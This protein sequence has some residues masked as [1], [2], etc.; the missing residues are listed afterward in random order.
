MIDGRQ[1]ERGADFRGGYPGEVNEELAWFAGRYL[2]RFLA[3]EK[4]LAPPVRILV[5]RDG[6]LS[7]APLYDALIRGLADAGATPIPVELT[8]TDALVWGIGTGVATATAGCMVTASHNPP[9]DNGIKMLLRGKAAVETISPKSLC[10]YF[11][12]DP[13][14]GEGLAADVEARP[15][16]APSPCLQLVSQFVQAACR[17]APARHEFRDKVVLDPGNGVGALFL[18]PLQREVP[19]AVFSTIFGEIDGHFPNRPSNPAL[20][21][22]IEQTETALKEM[23]EK[24]KRDGAASPAFT[25]AFDGDADRLFLFDDMGKFVPG[26][27]LLAHLAQVQLA[28]KRGSPVVF[29]STCSW[30]VIEVIRELGGVPVICKVGQDTVKEALE[31]VRAVFGGES[32]GH[33]NFP[34]SYYQDSGLIALMTFWQSLHEMRASGATTVSDVLRRL[35]AWEAS[36]EINIKIKSKQWKKIS[37][38]AV[39]E[40]HDA[41]SGKTDCTV[42]DIDGV[43][44]YSPATPADLFQPWKGHE[45]RPFR[46]VNFASGDYRPEWW[47]S[48]RRSN[49]EPLIRLNVEAQDRGTMVERTGEFLAKVQAASKDETEVVVPTEIVDFGYLSEEEQKEIKSGSQRAPGRA[50]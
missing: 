11:L 32:S 2:V 13:E 15:P 23:L 6:R 4:K 50:D 14:R 49:N 16:F 45:A 18:A 42:L 20:P 12:A 17:W 7:S 21:D 47:V 19:G 5:G 10:P 8:T 9:E 22:A 24:L 37:A 46:R 41:A 38:R 35:K 34:G 31:S 43:G 1:F 40:L 26:D 33:F 39:Q 44:I 3:E 29:T 48:L 28:G 36:G 25:A 30:K 27:L